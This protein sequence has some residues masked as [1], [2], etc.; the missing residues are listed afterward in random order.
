MGM[1]KEF[2]QIVI[3]KGNSITSHYFYEKFLSQ[4]LPVIFLGYCRAWQIL[5]DVEES[6]RDNTVDLYLEGLFE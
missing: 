1:M 5:N 4:S 3:E 6:M 2:N